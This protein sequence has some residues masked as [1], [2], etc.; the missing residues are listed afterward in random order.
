MY[1]Y[2]II[3]G[4]DLYKL[5]EVFDESTDGRFCVVWYAGSDMIDEIINGSFSVIFAFQ[6]DDK[7]EAIKFINDET[8]KCVKQDPMNYNDIKKRY[9]T[10]RK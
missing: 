4:S 2:K 5:V 3:G 6:S 7:K 8:A 1:D 10:Y 9:S